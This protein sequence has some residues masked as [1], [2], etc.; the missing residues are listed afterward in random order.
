MSACKTCDY[1]HDQAEDFLQAVD[2]A[3]ACKY[4]FAQE[5]EK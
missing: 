4:Y 2:N 5:D 3:E 1:A